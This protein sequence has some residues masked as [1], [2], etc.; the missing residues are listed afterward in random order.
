M[1]N[2]ILRAQISGTKVLTKKNTSRETGVG[3]ETGRI[4]G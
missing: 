2:F 3:R 1:N 4:N